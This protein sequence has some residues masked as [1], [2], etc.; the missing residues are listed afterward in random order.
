MGTGAVRAFLDDRHIELATRVRAFAETEIAPRP[1]PHDDD[2][3]RR[4]ARSFAELLGSGGWLE[5][6]GAQDLRA[7]CLIRESLA[8]ASPLADAIFALQALGGTPLL[9]SGAGPGTPI[10]HTAFCTLMLEVYY[11]FLP[12][13]GQNH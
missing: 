3:G 5:P 13:T 11:R 10:Y 2:A 9:L 8:A 4:E 6:I 1:E 7:C 12:G